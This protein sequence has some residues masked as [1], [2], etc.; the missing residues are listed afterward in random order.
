MDTGRH[1][2]SFCN[3]ADNN[4]NTTSIVLRLQQNFSAL[5]CIKFSFRDNLA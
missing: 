3:M 5:K 4:E 1:M 2:T